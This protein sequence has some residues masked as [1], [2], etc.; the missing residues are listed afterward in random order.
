VAGKTTAVRILA[1]LSD[2]DAEHARIAGYDVVREASKVRARIGLSGPAGAVHS[3]TLRWG[4][5]R[6]LAS[7]RRQSATGGPW[8]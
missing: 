5:Y 2:P 6:E 8:G 7:Q 4:E 3:G 1:T